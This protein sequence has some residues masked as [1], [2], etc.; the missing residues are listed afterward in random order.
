MKKIVFAIFVLGLLFAIFN[1]V[2]ARLA[3]GQAKE[4]EVDFFYSPACSHCAQQWKF[5]KELKEKY[6]EIKIK[7]LSIYQKDNVELLKEVYKEYNIPSEYYG[8]VPLTL[9]DT[10]YF[11][12]FN[13][14]I[15]ENI[16]NC[17]LEL[18]GESCLAEC[19]CEKHR[20]PSEGEF[21]LVS[22]EGKIKLPLIGEINIK[23]Y[24][25]PVLAVILGGLDGFNVCSLGA[26]VLI[27]GLVLAPKSR[28]KV[29][30][31]GGIFILTTA[32]VYGLLIVLWY[33]IFSLLVPYLRLMQILI[34]LLGIGGGTYFLREFIKFKKQGPT[35]EIGTGK[36]MI[37][38]FSSKFQKQLQESR[39]ILLLLGIVLLFAAVITIVEFPCSAA[40]PV[41]FAGILSQAHLAGFFYLLYISLFLLFYML[42]EIIVFLLAFLTMKVWLA[43]GRTLTWITLAEAVILFGLGFYYLFGFGVL[44]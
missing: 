10:K 28:K 16:E 20:E 42:D 17:I 32:I 21:T 1:P 30:V 26:L 34:G 22:L 4:I 18:M 40:V 24:S 25:L 44:L 12:G 41:V 19:E 11:V 13:K 31:F 2:S 29:L 35:C 33:Q 23:K 27:L 14:E 36:Q 7:R 37:S 5:L 6:P 15:G 3:D 9:I 43:S 8:M 39:N 38:R